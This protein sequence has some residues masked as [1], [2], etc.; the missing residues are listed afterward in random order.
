MSEVES[1]K[2]RG[3]QYVLYRLYYLRLSSG[4]KG[5]RA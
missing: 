4:M 2:D 5:Q 1:M 3:M